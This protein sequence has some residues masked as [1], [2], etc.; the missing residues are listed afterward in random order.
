MRNNAPVIYFSNWIII[1][2]CLKLLL[3][4]SWLFLQLLRF[5]Y[6][7][8]KPFKKLQNYIIQILSMSSKFWFKCVIFLFLRGRQ[9]PLFSSKSQHFFSCQINNFSRFFNCTVLTIA[10]RLETIMDSDRVMV[11][12]QGKVKYSFQTLI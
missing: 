9:I 5:K 1:W 8:M 6:L 10:H 4:I 12:Q 7:S 2:K 3:H 11:I